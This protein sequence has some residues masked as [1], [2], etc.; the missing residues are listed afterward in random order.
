M[1]NGI[2]ISGQRARKFKLS[3]FENYD[4]IYAMAGDVYQEIKYI[5]GQKAD[6]QKVDYFLNE[7]HR[8][9]PDTE[10]AS[11]FKLSEN[12]SVPDPWYGTEGGYADVFEMIDKTCD[13]IIANYK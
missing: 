6:M 12:A 10:L 1:L 5:G 9:V 8:T 2:D 11:G 3:D 4:R 7:L 13:A